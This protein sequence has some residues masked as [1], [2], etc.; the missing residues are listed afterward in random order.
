MIK[1]LQWK[2]VAVILLVLLLLFTAIFSGLNLYMKSSS[3]RQTEQL[4]RMIAENDGSLPGPDQEPPAAAANRPDNSGD[5]P[6]LQ[7]P[8]NP[9]QQG[10]PRGEQGG[11]RQQTP[12]NRFFY[13]KLDAENQISELG[14]ERM[15]DFGEADALAYLEAALSRRNEQGE[16]GQM[17]Y[18]R[19][20]KDY[21]SII[22]FAETSIETQM[23]HNLLSSSLWLAAASLPILLLLAWLLSRWAVRP[24]QTAFAK[25]RRF[26]SDASHELKTPLTIIAANA[27][28]LENE[29]GGNPRLTQ[30]KNQCQR[31]GALIGDL[32]D[33]ARTEES[34]ALQYAAFDLSR[35]LLNATLEFESRA[36]EEGKKLSYELPEG[37]WLWGDEGKIRQV[38]GILLDN[39]L[40][41]SQQAGEIKVRL[42]QENGKIAF[43]VYNTGPGVDEAE[44][45]KI[46]ER[47]YRSDSSR[48]RDTGGYGLGLAIAKAIVEAH[49]GKILVTGQTGEWVCFTILLT[50][51]A[52][53]Q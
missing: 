12:V 28:V 24:V 6:E 41:H 48:S 17:Q 32:L 13:V 38:L 19:L 51:Q 45:G 7:Q 34:A 5:W 21:G 33:L 18:L 31:M 29:I 25:Q 14:L 35:L 8:T 42:W 40:R 16:V 1:R 26:I 15:F 37:I 49:K 9:P 22:V 27:E 43:S 36:F 2:I 3:N 47:F 11:Q 4:L 50:E 44:R 10:N 20:S 53:R 46:F 23:L 30:M 52:A 39:A